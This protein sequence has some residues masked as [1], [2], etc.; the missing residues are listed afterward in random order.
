MAKDKNVL[1]GCVPGPGPNGEIITGKNPQTGAVEVRPLKFMGAT[2]LSFTA[3]LG[4]GP[5]EESTLDLQLI[6]DCKNGDHF[7]G[8]LQVGSPVFFNTCEALGETDKNRCFNFGGFVQNIL[9]LV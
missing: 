4:I 7:L 3:N 5:T 1:S 9:L 8:D 2:V 6:E